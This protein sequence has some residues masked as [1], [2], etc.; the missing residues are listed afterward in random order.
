M[1]TLFDIA[2]ASE[3]VTVSGH[4]IPVYGVSASSILMILGRFP[5]LVD[6]Y[7]EGE[8]D[9]LKMLLRHGGQALSALIA[10]AL[11]Y[12]GDAKAEHAAAMLPAHAQIEIAASAIRLTM[13]EGATPFLARIGDLFA[14]FGLEAASAAPP[15]ETSSSVSVPVRPPLSNG[16]DQHHNGGAVQ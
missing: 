14:T 11:G 5:E 15:S 7:R 3:S 1:A 8:T 6:A 9:I 13:P 10:A 2:P 4:V 12:P 16:H